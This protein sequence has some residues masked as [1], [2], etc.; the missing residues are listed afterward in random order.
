MITDPANYQTFAGSLVVFVFIL[1]GFWIELLAAVKDFPRQIV[2]IYELSIQIY[3]LITINLVSMTFYPL[4]LSWTIESHPLAAT[5]LMLFTCC[6]LLKLISYHHV[7]HDVRIL[8][9]RTQLTPEPE[10]SKYNFFNLPKE[11][12]NEAL[13][14]PKNL[15]FK[16]LLIFLLAPTCCY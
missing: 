9:R 5:F 14:Y 7:Y 1:N 15:T 16:K 11:V 3:I 10:N 2:I 12:Y 4:W 13:Q 6:Y 8:V